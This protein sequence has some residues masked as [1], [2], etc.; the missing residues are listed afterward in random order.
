MLGSE[1]LRHGTMTVNIEEQE[2]IIGP[3]SPVV[4][5]SNKDL[6]LEVKKGKWSRG[7]VLDLDSYLKVQLKKAFDSNPDKKPDFDAAN[8]F[9][10][11]MRKSHW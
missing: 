7:K 9:L 6:L 8:Q 11:K 5:I 3:M 4:A 10:L 1:L 2:K